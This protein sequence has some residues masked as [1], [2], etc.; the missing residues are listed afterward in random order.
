MTPMQPFDAA[1]HL[2]KGMSECE[3]CGGVSFNGEDSL[4]DACKAEMMGE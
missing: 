1:W 4:C 3:G 2:L